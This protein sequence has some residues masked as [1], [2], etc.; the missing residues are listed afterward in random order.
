MNHNDEPVA[1][2]IVEPTENPGAQEV[3]QP[4][5][6]LN[7]EPPL[8]ESDQ[9]SGMNEDPAAEQNAGEGGRKALYAGL[10]SRS[11]GEGSAFRLV[12][13]VY[14]AAELNHMAA[15]RDPFGP[16]VMAVP[17]REGGASQERWATKALQT[18]FGEQFQIH[19]VPVE[20]I[21]GAL[22]ACFC[23]PRM[24]DR[25]CKHLT[26]GFM[27]FQ[28][29]HTAALFTL[30]QEQKAWVHGTLTLRITNANGRNHPT[31]DQLYTAARAAIDEGLTNTEVEEWWNLE[32]WQLKDA[33]V[34]MAESGISAWCAYNAWKQ[35]QR[36]I[37]KGHTEHSTHAL[38]SL[39][40]T[41]MVT[42]SHE[43]A[44]WITKANRYKP[45]LDCL[46]MRFPISMTEA[47]TNALNTHIPKLL[48]ANI[49][50]HITEP[51]YA[52][53]AIAALTNRVMDEN[54]AKRVY[55]MRLIALGGDALS[56]QWA[57]P[58]EMFEALVC[59]G[60]SVAGVYTEISSLNEQGAA[61]SVNVTKI[62]L[63]RGGYPQQQWYRGW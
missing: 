46:D 26:K 53:T 31:R 61:H 40:D 1:E 35:N 16:I 37:G 14:T 22:E 49:G 43:V 27:T 18:R 24:T 23:L 57:N 44:G 52:K 33:E 60:I 47:V 21:P 15:A 62:A 10:T 28:N 12:P 59:E 30:P 5:L 17:P 3:L 56:T 8:Q 32:G 29:G 25:A 36:N 34:Q 50:V 11:G 9:W 13:E 4:E 7:P 54:T 45:I 48:G 55:I 2:P 38:W 41:G 19:F 6:E 20:H 63:G 51:I 42:C 39:A 58:R